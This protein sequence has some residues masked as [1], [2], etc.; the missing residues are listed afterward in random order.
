MTLPLA[1]T[2]G[3]P[4]GIGPDI[5][6]A[7]WLKRRAG[8]R[9][10]C[11][12]GDAKLLAGRAEQ[13]GAPVPVEP[14]ARLSDAMTAWQGALP[15]LHAPLA[16]EAVAGKPDAANG[17]MVIAAIAD[18]VRAVR[19]GEAAAVV[20]NPIAKH[21][22]YAAGFRYPGQTEFLGALAAELWP[23]ASGAHR[24]VMMLASDVLRV[25]P[26]T[27]H[28]PLAAVPGLITSDRIKTVARIVARSLKQ[29]FGIA[30]PRIALTGL[31]PHAGEAGTIGREEAET[32]APAI[33]A[34]RSDGLDVTGPYS[35]DTLFHEDARAAYDA[36]IT[37]YHDQALI[38]IKTLAFDTGVN[39]TIGLPFVRTSPD[40]GT[41]FPLA[42]TGSARPDSLIAALALASRMAAHRARA[43]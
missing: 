13:L 30:A 20:T 38:P 26:L 28:E 42:G 5:T 2:L 40:H 1:I 7:A 33:A 35:A 9:P 11:V 32:I 22:L 12:L 29:D 21:V 8:D 6:L 31:N 15:V 3:D 25:V 27:I 34:L 18:A 37:M 41:A 14:V 23:E 24:P 17:P 39:T 36:A 16:T 43:A 19:D 4:A 10:F